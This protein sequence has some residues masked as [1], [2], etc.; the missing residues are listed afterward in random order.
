MDE[1]VSAI[2][3]GSK[4]RTQ[5]AAIILGSITEKLIRLD[6]TLPLVVVKQRKHNLNFLEALMNI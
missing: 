3:I 6:S 1:G 2:V 5:A 4:G